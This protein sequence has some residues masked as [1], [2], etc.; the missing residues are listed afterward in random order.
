MARAPESLP[1]PPDQVIPPEGLPR[2]PQA[3]EATASP[4]TMVLNYLQSRGYKPTSENVRR[5][6][7]ANQR[8]PGVIPGLRSDRPAT[9]EEDQAAM[10]AA[11]AGR[12]S[13]RSGA[14]PAAT[15]PG[16]PGTSGTFG[17]GQ[18]PVEGGPVPDGSSPNT[19]AQPAPSAGSDMSWLLPFALGG[20]AGA[21]GLA[22]ANAILGRQGATPGAPPGAAPVTPAPA[23][24]AEVPPPVTPMDAALNKATAEPAPMVA[25]PERLP[26][27]EP[28]PNPDAPLPFS[29]QSPRMPPTAAEIAAV[30]AARNPRPP[31][32]P[33]MRVPAGSMP[34]PRSIRP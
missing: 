23:P 18:S 4:T 9:E 32:R 26:G 30:T 2:P 3:T 8:D 16:T 10:R 5:A 25:P 13:S 19:S 7:E 21:G 11:G 20:G 33:V 17:P 15:P 29:S 22:L 34:I 28:P 14:P 1:L 6:L 12:G 31:L 24:G 27:A